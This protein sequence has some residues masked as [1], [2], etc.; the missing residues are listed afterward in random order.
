MSN[1]KST[2]EINGKVYNMKSGQV[3]GSNPHAMKSSGKIDG[4]VGSPSPNN[5]ISKQHQAA[6]AKLNHTGRTPAK[7]T[8]LVSVVRHAKTKKSIHQKKLKTGEFV[9]K[10]SGNADKSNL[11][12][13]F[14]KINHNDTKPQ[15]KKVH[16]SVAVKHPESVQNNAPPLTIQQLE[17]KFKNTVVD[18][19]EK[20]IQDASSHIHELHKVESPASRIKKILHPFGSKTRAALSV[21]I[22]ISAF[23]FGVYQT[24]P[25]ARVRMAAIKANI[26]ATLPQYKPAGFGI[27]NTIKAEPGKV[28]ITYKSNTQHEEF[29]IT[30]QASNWNSQ[31]L[32]NNQILS[33]SK[34]FQTYQQNGKTVYVYAGN[35]VTWVDKGILYSI[36]GSESLSA[37]QL[38][39]VAESL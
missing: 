25:T 16:T 9:I 23:A 18:P 8:T 19:F 36:E 26:P 21:T 39:K 27:D 10:S 3:I 31:S 15:I 33:T 24:V 7:S 20:A 29:K 1:S 37:D 34:P 12:T 17:D 22:I 11:I 30:Q 4:F 13:K 32:L 5:T 6:R 28:S 35:N 14:P 38:L 2:V